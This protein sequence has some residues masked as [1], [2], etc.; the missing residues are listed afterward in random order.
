MS[1]SAK[2]KNCPFCNGEAMIVDGY[3]EAGC[4]IEC[5]KCGAGGVSFKGINDIHTEAI[6]AWNT[7]AN[8]VSVKDFEAS[9][10]KCHQEEAKKVSHGL[11]FH[12]I[13]EALAKQFNFYKREAGE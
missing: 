10:I 7:R 9:L 1:N 2:L 5:K 6:K 11:Y 12:N 8:L 13:A 3:S 4:W